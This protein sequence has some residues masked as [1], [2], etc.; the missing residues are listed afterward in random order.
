MPRLPDKKIIPHATCPAFLTSLYVITLTMSL[1]SII[2]A[3][4]HCV[5]P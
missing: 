1:K 4:P 5:N 3:A 2:Y